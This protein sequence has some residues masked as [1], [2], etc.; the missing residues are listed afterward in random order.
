MEIKT[1]V[2]LLSGL[3]L[4]LI[5]GKYLVE[6]S[7]VIARRFN[8]PPGIIGLTIV[9]F[10]TSAPELLV[11]IQAAVHGY[12]DMAM[13][14][15]IGSNISNILLVLGLTALIFP[16]TLQRSSVI[17][18]WPIMI[19]LTI[20]LLLFLLD[21][22]LSRFEGALFVSLLL[23]YILFSVRQSRRFNS[24]D[25]EKPV[26]LQKTSSWVSGII[27]MVSCAGLA[28]GA[29]LL[30]DNAAEMAKYFGI[31]ERVISVSMVALGT[32]LPELVTS[33][34]AAIKKEMEISVGN[35]LGS[36]IM[37]IVSVLGITALIKPIRTSPE[38]L[39]IDMP[40]MIGSAL[41]LFAFMLPLKRGRISRIQGATM[42]LAY[43]SYIYYIFIT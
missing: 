30:V 37:N 16:L 32:S 38:V 27:F 34:I 21:Y 15:V 19:F 24:K 10:G 39:T 7:V 26:I 17:V 41:L 36:N 12:P 2:F 20:L 35:I 8:I 28:L 13:G 25:I 3:A 29:S 42:V 33:I 9:A 18:D 1:I 5:S 4:L 43:A 11:S 31:S 22:R 23:L 6:S 14:N 40:W